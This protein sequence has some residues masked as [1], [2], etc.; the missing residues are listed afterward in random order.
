MHNHFFDSKLFNKNWIIYIIFKIKSCWLKV[1]TLSLIKARLIESKFLLIS[2]YL[3]LKLA[4]P[5][6]VY[7]LCIKNLKNILD[8][9]N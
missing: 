9:V 8:K 6:T 3:E 4:Q 5:L 1:V 2:K 7:E